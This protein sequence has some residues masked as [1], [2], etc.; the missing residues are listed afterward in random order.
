[1][2]SVATTLL[3]LHL[4]LSANAG[5]VNKGQPCSQGDNRLQA[6][7]YQFWSDCNSQTYCA[8]NN[9]CV[10]RGCRRD[11]FPF[12]YAQGSDH[13]PDKCERGQFCPDEM[14]ACQTLLSVGSACQLNRDDQCEAP[15]NFK[16]LADTTGRGLNVNGSVCL[17]NVCMWANVTVGLSCVVENIGYTAY[18]AEGEFI[19][20]VSRGNC[21]VG[22]YCDSQQR[23]CMQNKVL[24]EACTADKECDSWNCMSNGACGVDASIPHHFSPWV[25]AVVAL[26]IIGGMFGTLIGLFVVHRKQRDEEREKRVQY[27]RE[28]NT[29]HQNLLQMR[30]SARASILSLPG[31]GNSARSTVYST[32]D[33]ANSDDTHTPILQHAAKGSGLR[34]YIGD[35]GSSEYDEG[36]IVQSSR[37]TD[38]RF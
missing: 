4:H 31:H 37:K 2:R 8:A 21:R 16:E 32:R 35:D 7:T 30:E 14:D 27:W 26:G 23:V 20:I 3:L 11:D 1:M 22:L 19:N 9:T 17:N 24:G 36:S 25:Y 28:Q 29:F 6:G 10:A 12:G 33:G 5:S 38:G 13:I 34:N 15:D 18:E